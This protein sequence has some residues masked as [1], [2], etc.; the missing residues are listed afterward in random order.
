MANTVRLLWNV[1]AK[2]VL[3][4]EPILTYPATN[5]FMAADEFVALCESLGFV[6]EVARH[7]ELRHPSMTRNDYLLRAR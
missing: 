1:Y 4:G 5:I 6:V 3:R 2:P 7:Q